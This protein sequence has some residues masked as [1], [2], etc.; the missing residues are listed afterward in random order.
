MNRKMTNNVTN[1]LWVEKYRPKKVSE[2]VQQNEIKLLLEQAIKK[3][4]LTH[5]LFYGPP[6]TGKT[7]TA[8][9]LAKQLYYLPRKKGEDKWRHYERNDKLFKERVIELNASDESGIKVVRD[10]IKNFANS[11]I[12][13][14]EDNNNIPSFKIIILDEADAMTNDS[15]FALRRII[16]LFTHST[17]FILIC[18]YVTKIIEPLTSRCSKFRFQTISTVSINEII[19]NISTKENIII[20][21]DVIDTLFK[22]TKGD[23][24][25]VINLLQRA[26]Y[27]NKNIDTDLLIDISG[28]ISDAQI[29]DIWNI[30]IDKQTDHNKLFK[31]VREIINEGYSS[32]ILLNNIFEKIIQDPNITDDNKR[33]IILIVSKIDYE[34]LDNANE[35]IQ[36]LY[37]FNVIRNHY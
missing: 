10:K 13:T 7:S 8:L 21:N 18:N 14:I 17:R 9:A 26:S 12:N 2:I 32:I 19:N 5:M 36:L 34:L 20:N 15:Q 25:K 33:K 31:L 24:R 29:D 1:N 16:E 3:K 30:V 22:I 28:Q 23:L 6:G 37:L 35:T 27:I 11:A 4:N